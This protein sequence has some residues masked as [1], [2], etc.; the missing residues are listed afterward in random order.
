[1]NTRLTPDNDVPYVVNVTDALQAETEAAALAA[2][3]Q[4]RRSD[5]EEALEHG[6][7]PGHGGYGYDAGC[8]ECINPDP[9]A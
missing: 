3:E 9:F 4:V 6:Y 5:L 2:L 8:T 7:C 1:M